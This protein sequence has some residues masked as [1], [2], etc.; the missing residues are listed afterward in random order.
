MVE[1]R[2]EF[3]ANGLRVIYVPMPA[4]HSATAFAY[5]RMGPRFEAPE[6]NGLS[7][8]AE[9][10]LFKGTERFPDPESLSRRIDAHGIEFSGATMAEY[11]EVVASSHSRHFAEALALLAEVVLRPRFAQEHVEVER[12]VVLEEMGQ[13]RD[14]AD[15]ASI[16]ELAYELMWPGQG[17]SFRCLGSPANI[18]RFARDDIEAHYRRF[19]CAR[20]MVLCVAGN[21]AERQ[22][23]DILGSAFGALPSGQPATCAPLANAQK[24]PRCLFRSAPTQMAYLKLCHKAC[25]Y[26]DAAVYPLVLINDILGGGVTSRLFS[27]LRERDGLVYDV[28]SGTTLFSDCGWVEVATTTSPGKVGATVEATVQEIE[29]L[30]DKGIPQEQLR[31]VQERVACTMEILEDSPPDV[32]EW[33]GTR[34]ILLLPEKLVTPTEEAERL[35]AVT[36]AEVSKLAGEVFQA[37]RRS[38]VIVG[39]CSWLQRRRIRRIVGQ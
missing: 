22:V 7:H 37:A 27:R 39:P 26:N 12:S 10:L 6:H 4:F 30:A 5:I 9:H 1:C 14:M 3:L 20:N 21:F 13:Y 28:S 2:R 8:F 16:D 32:A 31:D 29:R 17:Q 11:T 23:A 38:L 19:L 25:S 33:L 24:A 18:A 34:E 36:A 35:K 15:G